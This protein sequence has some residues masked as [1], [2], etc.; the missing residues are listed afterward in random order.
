MREDIVESLCGNWVRC[1]IY[2][3]GMSSLT[4]DATTIGSVDKLIK[5]LKEKKYKKKKTSIVFIEFYHDFQKL[6]SRD[7]E[8]KK[9]LGDSYIIV[10]P[11]KNEKEYRIKETWRQ[12]IFRIVGDKTPH[13]LIVPIRFAEK[14]KILLV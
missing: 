13:V 7:N 8:L 12:N 2:D 4:K 9:A 3:A 11:P 1:K 10:K 14:E 5:Y 6:K